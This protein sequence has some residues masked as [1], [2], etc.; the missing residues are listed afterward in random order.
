MPRV[1]LYTRKNCHLCEQAH[2]VL[3]A[4]QS[5]ADFELEVV[6]IDGDPR[7]RQRYNEE[8]PVIAID[9]RKAFKYKVT[10]EEFLGKLAARS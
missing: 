6:D 5:R 7:L 2:E 3:E 1:T 4:A 10:A 9:G 8:V